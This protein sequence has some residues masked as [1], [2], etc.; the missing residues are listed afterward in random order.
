MK[1]WIKDDTYYKREDENKMLR[2][3]NGAWSINLNE[4]G[5]KGIK[6][7]V[8]ITKKNK[9][10]VDYDTAQERGFVRVMGLKQEPKLIVPLKV[11]DKT[12]GGM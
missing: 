9:Y 2:M 4:V 6:K 11:W 5:G 3:C 1:G 10:S 8:Y 12:K 7:V